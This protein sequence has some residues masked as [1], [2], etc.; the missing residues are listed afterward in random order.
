MSPSSTPKSQALDLLP[1]TWKGAF[2]IGPWVLLVG[3]LSLVVASFVSGNRS[4]F[5]VTC[6]TLGVA[7][8][9]ASALLPRASGTFSVAGASANVFGVNDAIQAIA[10]IA[11]TAVPD[12]DPDKEEKVK[13]YVS[14]AAGILASVPAGAVGANA[15][16]APAVPAAFGVIDT[17]A[18]PV[19]SLPDLV[20]GVFGSG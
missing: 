18:A 6:L 2:L 5:G 11:D 15:A 13:G 1:P 12:S 7:M 8:V 4:T 20:Q 16:D 9:V 19:V 17:G 3:G 14:A 10:K